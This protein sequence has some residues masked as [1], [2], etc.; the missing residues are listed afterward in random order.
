MET[1]NPHWCYT[2]WSQIRPSPRSSS[3]VDTGPV[4]PGSS[5]TPHSL[6]SLKR[7][8]STSSR[9]K[10][11]GRETK[12]Q[13]RKRLRA[14]VSRAATTAGQAPSAAQVPDEIQSGSALDTDD[15][16]P[17]TLPRLSQSA[18]ILEINNWIALV[19]ERQASR[20]D[21]PVEVIKWA[22]QYTAHEYQCQWQVYLESCRYD[23]DSEV[24]LEDFWSFLRGPNYAH[25]FFLLVARDVFEL[26]R[27]EYGEA[28]DSFFDRWS[29]ALNE[30]RPVV[31]FEDDGELAFH[32]FYRLHDWLQRALIQ[33]R[34][35]LT[36][37]SQVAQQATVEW[38][39]A[40][41]VSLH[42]PN[43]RRV[44]YASSSPYVRCPTCKRMGHVR[45]ARS[46]S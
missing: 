22:L 45:D 20:L 21:Q 35:L 1:S 7:P 8:R 29:K 15:P 30:I 42:V 39:K 38:Y 19:K 23:N 27:Q 43:N 3:V 32:Y 4:Q 10:A 11:D 6:D 41:D 18:S 12:C 44:R 24:Q 17:T 34:V 46:S 28:P 26:L 2:L 36:D 40:K 13:R 33:K 9:P 25:G 16:V 37:A 14:S 31:H 5:S